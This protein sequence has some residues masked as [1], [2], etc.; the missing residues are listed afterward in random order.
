[1]AEQEKY[2]TPLQDY[3]DRVKREIGEIELT[4][5]DIE[6]IRDA[7]LPHRAYR[8]Q[9]WWKEEREDA[10]GFDARAWLRAGWHVKSVDIGEERTYFEREGRRERRE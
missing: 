7:P 6:E 4:F 1:M 8:E 2:S 5:D 3:F 9:S 10:P